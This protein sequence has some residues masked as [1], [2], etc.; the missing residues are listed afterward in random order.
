MVYTV[1]QSPPSRRREDTYEFRAKMT[2]K[3]TVFVGTIASSVSLKELDIYS[4]FLSIEDGKVSFFIIFIL[5]F[6]T[7]HHGSLKGIFIFIYLY[8]SDMS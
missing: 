1:I 6:H 4:G 2:N 7:F 5:S 8:S 3:K